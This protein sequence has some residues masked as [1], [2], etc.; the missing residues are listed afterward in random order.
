MFVE[1]P[2]EGISTCRSKCPNG[3]MRGRMLTS[4]PVKV[5]RAKSRTRKW[6]RLRI[7]TAQS[8]YFSGGKTQG[9]SGIGR[10]E[11]AK[12]KKPARVQQWE[13]AS[14]VGRGEKDDEEEVQQVENEVMTA[15]RTAGPIESLTMRRCCHFRS[16]EE[17][18][19][20]LWVAEEPSQQV[21]QSCDFHR[22]MMN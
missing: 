11:D 3:E 20:K 2:G 8:G 13:M 19:K 17:C 16:G 18:W 5:C 14:K 1:A 21:G 6:R 10:V 9:D 4:S 15:I 12:K 7:K 22:W